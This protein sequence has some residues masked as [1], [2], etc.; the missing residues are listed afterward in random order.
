MIRALNR[1]LSR[2]DTFVSSRQW[3][4][5]HYVEETARQIQQAVPFPNK[6]LFV[7]TGMKKSPFVSQHALDIRLNHQQ[8]LVQLSRY[9][10]QILAKRSGHFLQFTEPEFV[11]QMIR[12]CISCCANSI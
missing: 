1:L 10:K 4:E 5:V 2:L 6:P 12:N 3:N 11:L 9:G 8:E 7:I